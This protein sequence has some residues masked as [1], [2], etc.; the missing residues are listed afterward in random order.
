MASMVERKLRR[1]SE[2]LR[3]LREELRVLDEQLAQFVDEADDARLR[4]LV[5]ETPAAEKE[6][7]QAQRHADAMAK[8]RDDVASEIHTLESAQDDLLD[9]FVEERR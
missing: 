2:Q 9:R 7:R 5:S 3:S 1:V 8:R 6:H 4:A